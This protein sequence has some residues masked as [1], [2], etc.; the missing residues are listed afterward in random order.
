[1]N[2]NITE[3]EWLHFTKNAYNFYCLEK[4]ILNSRT[5][6]TMIYSWQ[7]N[8]ILIKV[9]ITKNNIMLPEIWD[10]IFAM[11][12]REIKKYNPVNYNAVNF[13]DFIIES[14]DVQPYNLTYYFC[15]NHCTKMKHPIIKLVDKIKIG[16]LCSSDKTRIG[17]TCKIIVDINENDNTIASII[18]PLNYFSRDISLIDKLRFSSYINLIVETFEDFIGSYEFQS[19]TFIY[20]AYYPEARDYAKTKYPYLGY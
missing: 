17:Y 7:Y 14:K 13:N 15:D 11:V 6:K 8:L 20:K 12:I 4:Y 2:E 1:M 10:I 19:H 5:I 16:Q 18:S 9:H 3:L